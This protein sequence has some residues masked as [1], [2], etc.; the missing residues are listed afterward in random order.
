M[1]P[2]KA[3]PLCWIIAFIVMSFNALA[4]DRY[5]VGQTPSG[6]NISA[7]WSLTSGGAGGAGVPGASDMAIFD[8]AF[9]GNCIV[10]AAVNVLGIRINGYAGTI[11][12]NGFAI[13]MGTYGYTQHS[14]T[15]LG[16]TADINIGSAG[17]FV[18]TGGAFTS[19]SGSLLLTGLRTLNQAL[20]TISGGVF[21]ANNGSV[22]INPSPNCAT[23]V[24]TLDVLPST[25]FY[26]MEIKG[27]YNC[28]SSTIASVTDTIRIANN[29]I[30]TDGILN[31]LFSVKGN[32]IVN[33]NADGGMGT[34]VL[35][36][37]GNQTY[38]GAAGTGRTCQLVVDKPSGAVTP[39]P[40]A[41][42]LYVQS[43][44][45]L[46]GSFT[47]PTGTMNIGGDWNANVT[48][49]TH[50]GGIFNANNGAVIINP[51][52]GCATRVYALDVLPSTLF[53]NM[54][55]KGL[56]NCISSAITTAAGDTV[57][58]ANDFIHTD[59]I[60]NGLFSVKGNL[61]VNAAADGGTGMIILNSAGNQNYTGA[62][63][64]GRTCQLVIDKPSG[65]VTPAS[66][67]TDLYIQGL[68]VLAGSFTAPTGTMNIGGDWNANVTL[69]THGGGIFNANNGA[70]IIN[71]GHG[72]ASRVYA[73]DVLPS[74]LFYN[75]EIKGLYNCVSSTI[76]TATG[77]TVHVANDFFHTDGILNGIFSAKG[78]LTI[79]SDADGGTGMII[80][81]SASNQTYAVAA[82]TGR[83][84]QI[85]VN[86]PSGAVTPASGTTDLYIQGLSVLAGS[87]TAPTGTMN[88]G[89]D[90]NTNA[91]L[92]THNGGI[93]NANNGTA[94]I[95]PGHSC[96]SRTYMLDVLPSTLFYNIEIKGLY[97]CVNSAITTAAGDTVH[98]VN[99][100]V[101]TDGIL[102]G[103]FSVKGNLTVNAD[104]D[105]G[106]GMIILNSASSQTYAVST[107]AARTCQIVVNKPSGAVT[108]ASG[109]TDLYIQGLSVLA[110]S[111]TAPTGTMNIGGD[112]NINATLFTHGGGIFNANN[113][114]VIINPSHACATRTYTID[115]LPETRFYNF[116]LNG[117]YNCVNSTITSAPGDT[118]KVLNNLVYQDG[119]STARIVAA[120]NVTVLPSFDGGNGQLIF[121]GEGDQHFDLSGATDFFNG[122][123]LISKP[124]G[125]VNLNSA[126]LLDA[127]GQSITFNKGILVSSA[128]NL[129][130]IG[131]NV[132][133]VRASDS[134]FVD[135]PV[136]KIGNDAFVFPVGKNDHYAP[137]AISAP[138]NIADRFTAE[139]IAADPG[140]VYDR[141]AR[142]VSLENISSCEYWMLQRD[143]GL[144]DVL[145]TLSWDESRSCAVTALTNIRVARWDEEQWRDEGIGG[146][147]GDKTKGTIVSTAAVS[148]YGPF[149]LSSPALMIIL[150][151]ESL[152]LTGKAKNNN[153][154]L[155]WRT[156]PDDG[157]TNF[158][159]E[160]SKDGI[161]WTTIA[162]VHGGDIGAKGEF[163]YIDANPYE[164]ISYYRLKQL[165]LSGKFKYSPAISI[166]SRQEDL[167]DLTIYPNP[168]TGKFNL[169]SD[170]KIETIYTVEVY[171][172]VG[173]KVYSK[174]EGARVIDLSDLQDGVYTIRFNT[175]AGIIMKRI[176]I[177]K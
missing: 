73:L 17:A 42:D 50:G 36:G 176:I 177:K 137:I 95:N 122:P 19:S 29:L 84:C 161:R 30:H 71:P 7:N 145:V 25:L 26:N 85:V 88:I 155:K 106:T 8:N 111:F 74:T 117:L 96:A 166:R 132:A 13:V 128:S 64:T 126:C 97:N 67:T 46:A 121:N 10:D 130:T 116:T 62:A 1:Y 129:L 57:H 80:L 90:W 59:G 34:I 174:D 162:S 123:L 93:F 22:V 5:W 55:I 41:T 104:A 28:V 98:V 152:N 105:G 53:Y 14:G 31:G 141:T 23:R 6:W 18:L 133:V 110:G 135:G 37:S 170:I 109:T 81:N 77:D 153:N 76:T 63:G 144:S 56:Y 72:C 92:F 158:V 102:N 94:V 61:T 75:M 107:E 165:D 9:N 147:T 40:G 172:A 3:L 154:I 119:I 124:S 60:L 100:F 79:N 171:N 136:S 39:A 45:L 159:I 139:Y 51:G 150:P 89:G 16:G 163:S 87:F 54:E 91:T 58:V 142:P 78:N 52:H 43:F 21:N 24:Y 99:N 169:L 127:P 38:A 66:G 173:R 44:S 120:G 103:L 125:M 2:P 15:F 70:V 48:L 143:N 47:A 83:T 11:T 134:G 113:G 27:L 114:T 149:A 108:P 131:D 148:G 164:E 138:G 65:A 20:L 167:P 49:F 33:A 32:L 157:N 140:P 115:V 68:S 82:G 146:T 168:S 12:Q 175:V 156:L 160:K 86:K 69:F 151:A 118:L 112:W 35:N 101:H 4:T